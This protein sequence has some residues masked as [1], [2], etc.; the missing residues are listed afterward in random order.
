M[1]K[2]RRDSLARGGWCPIK[3]YNRAIAELEF[4]KVIEIR[5]RLVIAKKTLYYRFTPEGLA[6]QVDR[7]PQTLRFAP[8]FNGE[9]AE[10]PLVLALR[11]V[12]TAH[13]HEN[14]I[15]PLVLADRRPFHIADTP[16]RKMKL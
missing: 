6:Q 16:R 14:W 10:D 7:F 5:R 3:T 2:A 12:F 1:T 13:L 8:V 11:G 4:A 9:Q 15:K